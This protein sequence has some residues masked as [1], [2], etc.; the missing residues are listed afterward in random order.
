MI[1]Y[2]KRLFW[3]ILKGLSQ[4]ALVFFVPGI[5]GGENFMRLDYVMTSSRT[6]S[7][8][9]DGFLSFHYQDEYL[10][11]KTI[12]RSIIILFYLIGVLS[13]LI[14][15]KTFGVEGN[16]ALIAILF[17]TYFFT[18]VFVKL[19]DLTGEYL[20]SSILRLLISLVLVVLLITTKKINTVIF[21]LLLLPLI[22]NMLVS[23]Q[24]YTHNLTWVEIKLLLR[25]YGPLIFYGFFSIFYVLVDRTYLLKYVD[26][27]VAVT[28]AY[29]SRVIALMG[30]FLGAISTMLYADS[31]KILLMLNNWKY[32]K[33][34]T[35]VALLISCVIIGLLNFLFIVF[36]DVELNYATWSLV[37]LYMPVQLL[38][39]ILITLSLRLRNKLKH[40]GGGILAMTLALFVELFIF[41]KGFYIEGI[42]LKLLT[43]SVIWSFF[44]MLSLKIK[45]RMIY[46][47]IASAAVCI[48]LFPLEINFYQ[49]LFIIIILKFLYIGVQGIIQVKRVL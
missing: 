17:T 6:F 30:F 9:F 26:K 33:Y 15:A 24:L 18:D 11:S 45:L 37:L 25:D 34:I 43:T 7:S 40:I 1:K 38:G 14:F 23:R 4:A 46:E 16:M 44:I 19:F 32:S 36:L 27:D 42:M 49:K 20:L 22:S 41:K 2:F 3:Q 39:S 5:V 35:S 10:K 12:N 21:C 28:F 47:I 8:F 29:L 13:I 48:A 31:N